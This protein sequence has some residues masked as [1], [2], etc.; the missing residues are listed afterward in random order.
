MKGTLL[1]SGIGGCRELIFEHKVGSLD[2]FT[3]VLARAP[4]AF[5]ARISRGGK[6]VEPLRQLL[7]RGLLQASK[8]VGS[9][10]WFPPHDVEW[11]QTDIDVLYDRVFTLADAQAG[12]HPC[13][14]MRD[15]RNRVFPGGDTDQPLADLA[16]AT[17]HRVAYRSKLLK[18]EKWLT[19]DKVHDLLNPCRRYGNA[20][21][22][23]TKLRLDKKIV[24]ICEGGRYLYPQV[25]FDLDA[26]KVRPVIARV[27]S[28]LPTTL[29]D[30]ERVQWLFSSWRGLWGRTPAELLATHPEEVLAAAIE[31]FNVMREPIWSF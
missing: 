7:M 29:D 11:N 9:V 8:E 13:I 18:S 22:M 5:V 23:A 15:A 1:I 2:D 31:S 28:V 12:S 20:S 21:Q 3:D 24:G 27:L 26:R 30:W 19:S 4:H 17:V 14:W 16:I 10:M 6:H 25:Q